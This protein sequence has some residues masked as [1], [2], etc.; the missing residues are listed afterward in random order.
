MKKSMMLAAAVTALS[1]TGGAMA[2]DV[3]AVERPIVVDGFG[4][5]AFGTLGFLTFTGLGRAGRSCQYLAEWGS[6]WNPNDVASCLILE[7]RTAFNPSC[8]DNEYMDVTARVVSVAG[9]CS[10]FDIKGEDFV[11]VALT[12]SEI[13]GGGLAGLAI[14]DA[15]GV[16][17]AYPVLIAGC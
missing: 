6:P 3:R 14:I 2:L 8:I 17:V 5:A 16:D 12:L 1:I 9:Y 15:W 4:G 11:D 10:G 7:S 13:A